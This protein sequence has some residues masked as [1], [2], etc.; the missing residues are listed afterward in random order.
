MVRLERKDYGKADKALRSMGI[1][2]MF[3]QSVLWQGAEGEVYADSETDPQAFYAAHPY[4]MSLLFGKRGNP[5]F[6]E[7]L[8]NRFTNADGSRSK[9]EWLQ[10][11]PDG[12]WD[13]LVESVIQSHHAKLEDA[14]QAADGDNAILR[15]TRVNFRFNPVVFA[16]AKKNHLQRDHQVV[17]TTAELFHRQPGAV[18]PRFFFRDVEQFLE[19][20]KGFTALQ[21]GEPAAT[22]FS[23]YRNEGQLEIGIESTESCRGKG[24]AFAVCSAL[25]DFCL[26]NN[27]EPVWSC[28]LGNNGSYRLA[29]KLGFEQTVT[30]P[31]YR[32]PV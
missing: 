28:R 19:E 7:W 13:V 27:L 25:I 3:V 10:A 5:R 2:T 11:D 17:Q 6:E 1:N 20:G 30:L 4:G 26:E 16:E 8:S 9:P 18:V 22:A 15:D 24:Y 31:Y 23:A 32:L 29:Q 14:G 12:D 21:D